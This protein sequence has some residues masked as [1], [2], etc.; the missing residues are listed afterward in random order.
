[1]A[2][3][4]SYCLSWGVLDPMDSFHR[5]IASMSLSAKTSAIDITKTLFI[6]TIRLKKTHNQHIFIY[7][8]YIL[9]TYIT[10]TYVRL[11]ICTGSLTI[12]KVGWEVVSFE[13]LWIHLIVFI[14]DNQQTIHVNFFLN[15]FMKYQFIMSHSE[16]L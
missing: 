15:Y 4:Y 10:N 9:F 3:S 6:S 7:N 14:I 11:C 16:R 1:M 5:N 2:S 12:P 8:S 13:T